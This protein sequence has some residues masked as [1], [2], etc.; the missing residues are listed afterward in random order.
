MYQD[1]MEKIVFLNN[2]E[3]FK[4]EIFIEEQGFKII[5]YIDRN[6]AYCKSRKSYPFLYSESLY[7]ICQDFLDIQY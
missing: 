7:E 1:I 3:K 4:T 6:L 2:F 5:Q